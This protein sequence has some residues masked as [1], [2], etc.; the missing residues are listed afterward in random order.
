MPE[1]VRVSKSF[2]ARKIN[3]MHASLSMPECQRGFHD[4][5]KRGE[6]EL[7]RV[8]TCVIYDPCK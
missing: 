2:A 1:I 6:G 3:E 5:V 8:R 7:D 4:H